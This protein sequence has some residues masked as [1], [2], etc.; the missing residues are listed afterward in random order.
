[1]LNEIFFVESSATDPTPL[2]ATVQQNIII[3]TVTFPRLVFYQWNTTQKQLEVSK[4]ISL[5]YNFVMYA[6]FLP[7]K[8]SPTGTPLL[9]GFCDAFVYFDLWS[10]TLTTWK[11][12]NNLWFILDDFFVPTFPGSMFTY[13]YWY[14]SYPILV[15]YDWEKGIIVNNITNF[16]VSD[17]NWGFFL[18]NQSLYY[19]SDSHS[20]TLNMM[21]VNKFISGNSIN[22]P[23]FTITIPNTVTYHPLPL[24]NSQQLII[25]GVEVEKN[26]VCTQLSL[27]QVADNT[28]P[29]LSSTW[30]CHDNE[31]FGTGYP[32]YST[33]VDVDPN[34]QVLVVY[35]V[36][37]GQSNPLYIG[38]FRLRA[39]SYMCSSNLINHLVLAMVLWS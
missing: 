9:L 13:S 1:M 5:C 20:T 3:N 29:K 26:I 39:D 32:Y 6:K 36:R 4:N 30:G 22:P 38:V 25:L 34:T 14:P 17:V 2:M 27:Y 37:Q 18:I 23:Q 15:Q 7:P 16:M 33:L 35:L 12:T 19:L 21:N 31:T 10:F 8:Q 28:P 11:S 24:N